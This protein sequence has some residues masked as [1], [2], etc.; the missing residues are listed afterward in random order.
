MN[1]VIGY[2]VITYINYNLNISISHQFLYILKLLSFF[3]ELKQNSLLSI[4]D[5]LEFELS[6]LNIR[7]M[8]I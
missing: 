3:F 2:V 5:I 8:R 4:Q 6:I 7:E 1:N